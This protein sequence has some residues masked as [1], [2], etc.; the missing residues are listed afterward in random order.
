MP[1]K[2]AK[3]RLDLKN[4][5]SGYASASAQ[6][7]ESREIN[8]SGV[9]LEL[10]CP[11]CFGKDVAAVLA[12]TRRGGTWAGRR[13]GKPHRQ[14]GRKTHPRFGVSNLFKVTAGG[15]MGVLYQFFGVNDRWFIWQMESSLSGVD[16][17]RQRSCCLMAG[18]KERTCQ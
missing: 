10:A 7:R 8:P 3:S 5:P 12:D 16:A 14:S 15:Q 4:K 18:R 1:L 17:R 2:L 9:S 6:Y 11:Q 13:I